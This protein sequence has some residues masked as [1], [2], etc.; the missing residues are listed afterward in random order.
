MAFNKHTNVDKQ[1]LF[2]N[3]D[4][5]LISLTVIA[6]VFGIVMVASATSSP[7]KY[8]LVQGVAFIAGIIGIFALMIID[9]EYLARM[10]KYLFGASIILLIMVLIPGIGTVENGARSWFRLGSLIS[11]QP[12]EFVKLFFIIT[13]SNH[14]AKTGMLLNR[15]RNILLLCLHL[16]VILVLIL[17]QPDFGTATVFFCMAFV[18][19]FVAGLAW[20]YIAG[21]FGFLL[22]AAPLGWFFVRQ[23]YQK[24]RIINLF[25]PEND[26]MGTGYHVV[27]SKITAGS[28]RIFGTGLFNGASQYNNYLPARH[29]D[30]IF[31]VVC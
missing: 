13:F 8:I 6:A 15:P 20:K 25:N 3:F 17:V 11:I 9:Y 16:G 26:P 14:I 22:V 31:S 24:L 7:F 18:M 21:L 30:F 1:N 28:G 29:T 10:G 12:S 19:L 4:F 23:D 5:I 2:K 27:H